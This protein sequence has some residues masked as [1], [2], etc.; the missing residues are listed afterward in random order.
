MSDP[1][2]PKP[3]ISRSEWGLLFLLAAVQFTNILDF[4]IVMPLAPALKSKFGITSEQFGH[5]VAA[6]GYASCVGNLIAA[7]VLDRF[8]RRTALLFAYLGFTA[9]TILCG[10]A[11]RFEWLVAARAVAGFFGGILGAAVLSIV[12]DVFADYRR[13]TAM[14]TIMSAFAVASVVGIPLGLG[15]AEEFGTLSPF[16]VLG[17]LAATVWVGAFFVLPHLRGHIGRAGSHSSLVRLAIEPNHLMAFA[18]TTTLV[19]GSFTIVPYIA[20]SMIANAGQKM[21]HVKYVYLIAGVFT[22]VSTN[23]IGRLADKYGKRLVYRIMAILAIGVA[24]V[25]TNL[26]VVPLWFAALVTTAFMV[27]TSGRMVPAQALITASAAPGVRGGF[28][29]LNMAVQSIGMGLASQVAGVM[30]AQTD[31]GKLPG[32]PLVGVVAALSAVV[33]LYLVGRLKSVEGLP[34]PIAPA[35]QA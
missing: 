6:Y 5:I 16:L 17:A 11:S 30:V 14:G 9:A 20:D 22:F 28:L 21:E 31:D 26:P 34:S 27:T 3:T 33:S 35:S 13:G 32:Y 24:L 2:R 4:V 1:A 29:S 12:G 18:F 23:V 19:L 10:L 8:D 7:K 15:I 25:L